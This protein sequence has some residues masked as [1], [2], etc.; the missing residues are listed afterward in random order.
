MTVD[1]GKERRPKQKMSASQKGEAI[2]CMPASFVVLK[3]LI[4][5][6]RDCEVGPLCLI[7]E[8]FAL[9]LPNITL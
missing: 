8:T 3:S 1:Q 6:T 7:K 4:S 5:A 2:L 9:V